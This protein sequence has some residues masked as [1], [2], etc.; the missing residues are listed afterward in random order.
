M[1][2]RITQV[3]RVGAGLLFV[4]S[5]L[6][7]ATGLWFCYELVAA[8]HRHLLAALFELILLLLFGAVLFLAGRNLGSGTLSGRT[9]AL[10][11]NLIALPISYYLAQAGRWIAAIPIAIMALIVSFALISVE[12]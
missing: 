10:L 9:P 8:K 1:A 6:L 12:K 2:I 5:G 11:I 3:R 7:G 4:E